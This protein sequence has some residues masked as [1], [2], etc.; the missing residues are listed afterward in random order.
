MGPPEGPAESDPGTELIAPDAATCAQPLAK[1]ASYAFCSV[2]LLYWLLGVQVLPALAEA[3]PSVMPCWVAA[4]TWVLVGAERSG[5]RYPSVETALALP[6]PPLLEVLPYPPPPLLGVPKPPLETVLPG[7]PPCG[8]IPLPGSALTGTAAEA[9]LG[10]N[11]YAKAPTA[12]TP[13]TTYICFFFCSGVIGDFSAMGRV[14]F[15]NQCSRSMGKE[16]RD[17]ALL[18]SSVT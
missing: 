3:W 8:W 6:P 4:S 14:S 2:W 10:Q 11:R 5:V 15:V 16:K 9:F 13:P 17:Y 12:A 7:P 18:A 1:P